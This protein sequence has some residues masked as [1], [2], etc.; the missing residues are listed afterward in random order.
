VLQFPCI[1]GH[2]FDLPDDEAGGLIQCPTCSRLNDIPTLSD[3]RQIAPDGSYKIGA[4][5]ERDAQAAAADMAYVYQKGVYD[6]EGREIDLRLTPAEAAEIGVGDPIPLAPLSPPPRG[7]TPRYD[8]ETGELIAPLEIRTEGHNAP[9]EPID[10]SA[11]PMARAVVNY[12]TGEA[13]RSTGFVRVFIHLLAPMNLAV[14]ISVYL[15]HVILWPMLMVVLAGIF[16]LVVGVPFVIGAIVAHYGNIIEDAGPF[17]HDDLPRPLRDV[18]W[19]EDLWGPFCAV[20][21]SLL[22]CYGPSF[23][24]PQVL[25]LVPALRTTAMLTALLCGAVGTFL[26]PA[27][28]LTLQTS[29]TILNLRPD[30]VMALINGC[31]RDY[32]VTVVVWVIAGGSYAFGWGGTS[33]WIANMIH[34]LPLPAWM[35]SFVIT[36]PV[37]A[38]AVFMMHYFCMLE[39]ML[40]RLHYPTFPWVFQRHI[41]T[42]KRADA[43]GLPPSR[44]RPPTVRSVKAAGLR[45]PDR[46]H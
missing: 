30:R 33:L 4:A 29:G 42:A 25:Q 24:I 39:G 19:S 6:D 41:P 43:V 8:P 46:T 1:C 26:F 31:G 36:A 14:M 21:G 15:M 45:R 2:R 27:V 34:N 5:H 35:M 23:F 13:A 38:A 40:Y 44:R 17:A 16:F 3:L 9:A 20:F 37:L 7:G 18:N 32:F 22:L 28:L 12:A 11:I 10:P